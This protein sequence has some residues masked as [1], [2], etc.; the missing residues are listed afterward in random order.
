MSKISPVR[1]FS[2]QAST[3]LKDLPR[4]GAWILSKVLA[5]PAAITG[6]GGDGVPDGVRRVTAAV[7]DTLPGTHDS[8]EIRLKRAEAAVAKAKKA[9]QDALT[10]AQNASA[11]ADMAKSV[12]DEGRERLRQADRDAKQEVDRRT[13]QARDHFGQLIDQERDKASHDTAETVEHIA[14]DVQAQSEKARQE[15]EDAAARAQARIDDAHQQMATAR[16]LAAEATAAAQDVAEQ[17][18]QSA[19]AI[20]DDAEQRAQA[21]AQMVN[22][23]R[24]TEDLLAREA[25]HAVQAE[26]Q[27]DVPARLVDHT[28]AELLELAEPLEIHGGARMTKDQL[29]RAIRS[30]SRAK[31]RA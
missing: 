24:S 29:V 4:N 1:W 25:A 31:A 15:A 27:Q 3:G 5:A 28:K 7:A 6:S 19:K 23:A 30:A 14:A 17:A 8:V 11:R 2:H 9:E 18:R 12:N 26:Q 22:D 13:Q 16:A 20:A 10:E 21:A